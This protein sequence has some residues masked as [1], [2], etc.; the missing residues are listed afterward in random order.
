[1]D[2]NKDYNE[3]YIK[4]YNK[5]YNKESKIC[6]EQSVRGSNTIAQNIDATGM[7]I[8]TGI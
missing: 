2:N 1:M 6:D 4:D 7:R 5:D 3:D 8:R